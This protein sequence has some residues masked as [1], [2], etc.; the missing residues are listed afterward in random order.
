[1][2]EALLSEDKSDWGTEMDIVQPVEKEEPHSG[3]WEDEVPSRL[4]EDLIMQVEVVGE[5][6]TTEENTEDLAVSP[7]QVKTTFF[8]YNQTSV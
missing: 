1:M 8:C 4:R 7:E 5:A 3:V 6:Q 2:A